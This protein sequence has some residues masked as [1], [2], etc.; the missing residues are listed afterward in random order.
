MDKLDAMKGTAKMDF[1]KSNPPEWSKLLQNPEAIPHLKAHN[2]RVQGLKERLA[3]HIQAHRMQWIADEADR[4][5]RE[6]GKPR[7]TH[8]APNWAGS[9]P[10]ETW[11]EQ[12]KRNV[13]RR[14]EG[15]FEQLSTIDARMRDE[16]I[17][18]PKPEEI[19]G[20]PDRINDRT[21][22]VEPSRLDSSADNTPTE[23]KHALKQSFGQEM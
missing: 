17:N 10:Y 1:Q 23:R 11:L 4:L 18:R 8:P 16:I 5:W 6:R 9:Q 20:Q 19:P 13:Q 7:L 14:I 12:A 15:R 21:H 2:T 3:A 22:Q